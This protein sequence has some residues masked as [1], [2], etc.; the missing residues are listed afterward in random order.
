MLTGTLSRHLRPAHDLL[1]S[2][3]LARNSKA[4]QLNDSSNPSE[5]VQIQYRDVLGPELLCSGVIRG[6]SKTA[7]SSLAFSSGWRH[8]Q[9][10]GH[11]R[12]PTVQG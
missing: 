4:F 7:P 6:G 12:Q 10:L 9:G 3:D 5:E 8:R 11:L 1:A 2:I